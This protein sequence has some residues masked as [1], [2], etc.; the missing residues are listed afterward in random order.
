MV[1][2]LKDYLSEKRKAIKQ[3]VENGNGYETDEGVNVNANDALDVF[4]DINKAVRRIIRQAK[5]A[6]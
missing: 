6:A 2:E 4:N 5:V 3:A 1:E